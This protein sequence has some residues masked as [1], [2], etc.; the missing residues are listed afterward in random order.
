MKAGKEAETV[1]V[2][3]CLTRALVDEAKC[4]A[5]E[6]MKGSLRQLLEAG[7]RLFITQEKRR[8]FAEGWAAMAKDPRA[9]AINRQIAKELSV[10]DNDG[11]EVL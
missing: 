3:V 4:H 8:R 10:W 5:P 1:S 2:T 9:L 11:I 6:K 7:L